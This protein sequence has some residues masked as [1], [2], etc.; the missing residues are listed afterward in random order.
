VQSA[1]IVVDDS[2]FSTS[3]RKHRRSSAIADRR[4]RGRSWA[5][6]IT[7]T[8][9]S[10]TANRCRSFCARSRVT[11]EPMRRSALS[12]APA[13]VSTAERKKRRQLRCANC[14]KASE[15]FFAD[16]DTVIRLR[17]L[18]ETR[19]NATDVSGGVCQSVGHAV[20]CDF[21]VQT[22][23]NGSRSWSGSTTFRL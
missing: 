22:R 5:P 17:R 2:A 14:Y 12:D 1:L 21:A 20:V 10:A 16:P 19:T 3:T 6:S 4:R 13:Q 15:R 9:A 7:T 8:T 23:L 18:H 11:Y